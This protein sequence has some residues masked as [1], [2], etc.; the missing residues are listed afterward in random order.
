MQVNLSG[1]LYSRIIAIV[2]VIGLIIFLGSC[3]RK[4]AFQTSSVVPAAEGTVKVKKDNN[5]NYHIEVEITNLA[6]PNRLQP[7]KKTYV[8]WME[9]D[10][11]PTKNIGQINSSS[12]FLS[13]RL[14]A[15]FDAVSAIK[16]TRIFIT[17]EDD[18]TV[19][20]PGMQV[21]STA[22]L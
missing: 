6:E 17:A 18:G 13:K 12:G 4:I 20:N 10:L 7:P 15:S 9:T 8:V 2:L 19:Q 16:P 3:S 14:K 5:N 11:E 1:I 21:L 22:S